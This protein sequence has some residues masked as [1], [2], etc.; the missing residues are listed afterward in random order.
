MHT[1]IYIYLIHNYPQQQTRKNIKSHTLTTTK[2]NNV[3]V[4]LGAMGSFRSLPYPVF[5]INSCTEARLLLKRAV[6]WN[7]Y[8]I[9]YFN[10]NP[11]DF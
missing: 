6:E 9:N 2:E 8:F 1:Y 5:N 10:N 4:I 3:I 11:L 7:F